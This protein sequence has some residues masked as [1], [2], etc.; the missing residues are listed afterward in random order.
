[1]IKEYGELRLAPKPVTRNVKG[2]FVKGHK[3]YNKGKK[4][5]EYMNKKQL[6]R[7]RRSAIKNIARARLMRVNYPGRPTKKS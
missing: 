7:A 3:P 4:W 1:M 6:K 2:Q 5:E